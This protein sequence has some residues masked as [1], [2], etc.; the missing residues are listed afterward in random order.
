MPE[1][2]SFLV[3]SLTIQLPTFVRFIAGF[4]HEKRTLG[5][6]KY[7]LQSIEKARG[8]TVDVA[9]SCGLGRRTPETATQL[10][11]MMA[12]LTLNT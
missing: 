11:A 1:R 3:G 6:N 2:A 9:T 8:K 12:E 4:V 10:L 5:E 7:I